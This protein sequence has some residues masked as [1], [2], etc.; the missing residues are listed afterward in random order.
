MLVPFGQDFYFADGPKVSFF[1]ISVSDPHGR[2]TT[3]DGQSMGM[4]A[5]FLDE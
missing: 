1:G 3:L 4:V 5:Y 2:R